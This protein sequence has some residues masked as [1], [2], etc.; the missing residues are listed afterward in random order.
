M[1]S[2]FGDIMEEYIIKYSGDIL[3]L[4]LQVEVLS[5]N[6]A[7]VI[8]DEQEVHT[9]YDYVE[10]EYIEPAKQLFFVVTSN[11]EYACITPAQRASGFGL[12]GAGTVV[13]IIDSGVDTNHPEFRN[14]DGSSRILYLWDMTVQG[15]PPEGFYVG[16]EIT[17]SDIDSGSASSGDEIGHGTA[18][19]CIAAGNIGTAPEASLIVVKLGREYSR[20]TDIMRGIKYIIDKSQQS[21]MPCAINISYGTNDG[22]H[23]G[24]SLFETYIDSMTDK[25]KTSIICA[26]GNEGYGCHHFFGHLRDDESL[27]VDFV[28]GE[29]SESVYMTLWKNFVDTVNYSLVLPS[30]RTIGGI[31]LS[32]RVVNSFIDGASVS[33]LYGQPT[34]YSVAQNVYFQFSGKITGVWKLICYGE[35]VVDGRFDIWL[36][37][38][39]DVGKTTMF[40]HPTPELTMT[41]PSTAKK[42]IA[43][44]GYSATTDTISAFSGRGG[45]LCEMDVNIDIVAPA[46]NIVTARAGGGYDTFEGTSMAAPFVSGSA[47]LMMEWGIIMGN[48]PFL[49]GQRIKAFLRRNAKRNAYL[50]YPNSIWG[51]GRLCLYDSMVDIR[52]H[53]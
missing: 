13:G 27:S 1:H 4:G 23:N 49:Y 50:T 6:Y 30:G 25:W 3:S 42:V 10:I 40:L 41:L 8:I 47:A 12:T 20:S 17:K 5:E 37:T 33:V 46:E 45:P 14:A 51:Y 28:I 53:I 11:R 32:N 22:S 38:I 15:V 39:E 44:G 18:V 36:P 43:V 29:Q 26:A 2:K 9:L 19:A 7:I 31:T 24:S 34:H 52:N 16:T 48:D 21:G 35:D